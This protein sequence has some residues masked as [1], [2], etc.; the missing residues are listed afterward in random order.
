MKKIRI[1]GLL[2]FIF[3]SLINSLAQ[4]NQL[5]NSEHQNQLT[6]EPHNKHK[7]YQHHIAVFTGMTSNITHETN[8]WTVGLDY[9]YRLRTWNKKFGVGLNAE[10]LF[11]DHTEKL[12]GIPVFYH[13]IRGLKFDAAPMFAIVQEFSVNTHKSHDI[14]A[15]ENINEFGFR[16]GAIYDI[17]FNKFSISP[18]VNIDNI[19]H[20]W[21]IAFGVAF[22]FG[23]HQ[24]E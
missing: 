18:T 10:Y 11:G 1:I 2:G 22:G 5:H 24:I 15:S 16:I 19:G 6:H 20:S 7:I 21:A 13:P 4:N 17:H 9:E 12:F 14:E 8:L 3:L 23:F